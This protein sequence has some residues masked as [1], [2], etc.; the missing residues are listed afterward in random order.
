MRLAESM[1]R[2]L[3]RRRARATL[4]LHANDIVSMSK[5]ISGGRHCMYT[6][7]MR[8]TRIKKGAFMFLENRVCRHSSD[9][10]GAGASLRHCDRFTVRFFIATATAL[11]ACSPARG[12]EPGERTRAELRPLV[13]AEAFPSIETFVEIAM[14]QNDASAGIEFTFAVRNS[15]RQVVILNDPLE[16]IYV[17][18]A[19][20]EGYNISLPW[21]HGEAFGGGCGPNQNDPEQKERA[22]AATAARRPFLAS[23]PPPSRSARVRNPKGPDDVIDGKITLQ[24]GEEYRF[25]GHI[26]KVLSDPRAYRASTA[27]EI[28]E[29]KD[30]GTVVVAQKDPRAV[31]LNL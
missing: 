12:D 29:T 22:K 5:L 21:D 4:S 30:D 2:C 23:R 6:Q 11:V 18:V 19:N 3:L 26:V 17:R 16:R 27:N 9:R 24:A 20:S 25:V 10:S 8:S 15:G 7:S 1:C 13:E 14:T 31:S 28:L